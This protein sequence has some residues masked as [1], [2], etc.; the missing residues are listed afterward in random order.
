MNLIH[1]YENLMSIPQ[2]SQV[3]IISSYSSAHYKIII[4]ISKPDNLIKT[5]T[6]LFNSFMCVIRRGWKDIL[7]AFVYICL[8]LFLKSH[9][10]V[11]NNR[12]D[13]P[14][15]YPPPFPS[16]QFNL[17]T[18]PSVDCIRR[19]KFISGSISKVRKVVYIRS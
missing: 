16:R 19:G 13:Q 4:L 11:P 18:N 7:F 6:F 14:Y 15:F 5:T 10:H 8:K 3:L 2:V 17:P 1:T 9:S 12:I